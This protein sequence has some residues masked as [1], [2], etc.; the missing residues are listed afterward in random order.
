MVSNDA[1]KDAQALISGLEFDYLFQ[2]QEILKLEIITRQTE[3]ARDAKLQIQ[4][5]AA[6]AGLSPDDVIKILK[7]KSVKVGKFSDPVNQRYRNPADP[8]LTWSGRGRKPNWVV[9]HLKEGGDLN[10]LAIQR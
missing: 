10:E 1:M 6:E 2:L 9:A 4:K 7:A 8:S 3:R 5:I